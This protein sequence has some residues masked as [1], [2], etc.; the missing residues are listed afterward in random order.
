MFEIRIWNISTS[1]NWIGRHP[2]QSIRFNW[3]VISDVKLIFKV[4][5]FYFQHTILI[6]LKWIIEIKPLVQDSSTMK[7]HFGFE[8]FVQLIW[9]KQK[10]RSFFF[11]L[12][13]DLLILRLLNSFR[14]LFLSIVCIFPWLSFRWIITS[15]SVYYF[16]VFFHV[17]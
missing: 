3:S 1:K 16:R 4:D 14:I 5:K 10:I 17:A 2:F 13:S 6:D 9:N 7:K 11:I 12:Y 8:D 15:L